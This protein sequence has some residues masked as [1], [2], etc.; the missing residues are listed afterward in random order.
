MGQSSTTIER[1]VSDGNTT[2]TQVSAHKRVHAD[3]V[4]QPGKFELEFA[5]TRLDDVA[6]LRGDPSASSGYLFV[7]A[8]GFY[9]L[10]MTT[11][12]TA[13]K[14]VAMGAVLNGRD[15]LAVAPGEKVFLPRGFHAFRVSGG[16]KL[17]GAIGPGGERGKT[18]RRI[19]NTVGDLHLLGNSL[20]GKTRAGLLAEFGADGVTATS[21]TKDDAVYSFE[22]TNRNNGL[23]ETLRVRVVKPR[24]VVDARDR[25]FAGLQVLYPW[26]RTTPSTTTGGR[27]VV[28]A[29]PRPLRPGDPGWDDGSGRSSSR[30]EGC[31]TRAA[32]VVS[33]TGVRPF[34]GME[35][36]LLAMPDAEGDGDMATIRE[37]WLQSATAGV[38]LQINGTRFTTV[39]GK[40]AFPIPGE[41]PGNGVVHFR[42][43]SVPASSPGAPEPRIG[44]LRTLMVLA[45]SSR[46]AIDSF[47]VV[48]MTP[49]ASAGYDAWVSRTE[50]G[51]AMVRLHL[52][53]DATNARI[54]ARSGK[55]SVNLP[56]ARGASNPK[57]EFS[58]DLPDYE[59]WT[60]L[61]DY[62]I[63]VFFAP[64]VAVGT[65]A[66]IG[67]NLRY[68]A[69]AETKIPASRRV[70]VR[71]D[72]DA[73]VMRVV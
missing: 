12:A 39:V 63:E 8:D 18:F 54:I 42:V 57:R 41:R 68:L 35:V 72:G 22:T 17:L 32:M 47:R 52:S 20:R 69:D 64:T 6:K 46:N 10:R 43:D 28:V 5:M 7:N 15:D 2:A 50:A 45:T 33:D 56:R 71:V 73:H 44:G 60:S 4:R 25:V 1:F 49:A 29:V 23:R 26:L 3:A 9:T 16:G 38:V 66:T 59:E 27:P 55:A 58:F 21:A 67:T 11:T 24:S 65:V 48:G 62:D 51:T 31:V 30:D 37:V 53:D 19:P 40:N 34:P 36:R 14:V 70:R 13:G 61:K